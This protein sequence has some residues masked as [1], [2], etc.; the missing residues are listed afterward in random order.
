MDD[1]EEMSRVEYLNYR[2]LAERGWDIDDEDLF[3]KAAN[4]DLDE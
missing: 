1:E 2:V 4:A 3:E